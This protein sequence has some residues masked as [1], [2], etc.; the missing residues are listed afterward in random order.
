MAIK[1]TKVATVADD[2]TSE[3][4]T[5]EWNDDHVIDNGTIT[6]DH[7][8]GSIANTKLA[9]DPL[10]RANHTGTQAQSTIT[11]L[12]TDL[13]SKAPLASPTFTGTVTTAAVDVAGNNIDN[14]QNL[15]HDISTTTTTLDFSGDQLQTISISADTTFT[16]SNLAAGKSKT[17]KITTDGTLRT[18]TFP[19]WKFVGTKPTDQAASKVGILTLTSF[20]TTDADCVAAYAVEE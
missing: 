2:G 13:S 1:H 7:L 16:T 5:N 12:T 19:A 11:N 14:I 15:I 4:G 18:L 8:Q 20:G 17:I 3:V 9:T 6:N 10:A